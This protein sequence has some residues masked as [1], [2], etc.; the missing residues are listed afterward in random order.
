VTEKASALSIEGERL[1]KE[2]RFEEAVA[3]LQEAVR[4]DPKR[5]A[6]YKHL[7]YALYRLKRYEESVEASEKAIEL[8]NGFEPHYNSGLAYMEL[9]S[10]DKARLAFAF[11]IDYI[12]TGH[13][14]ERYTLAYYYRGRLTKQLG[15]AGQWIKRLEENL[16]ADPEWPRMRF[17]LGILYL[18]VEKRENAIAQYK[19]LKVSDPKLA[20]EL[21]KLIEKRGK[22][23]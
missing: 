9:N 13:W 11:A 5:G 6:A 8:L 23:N 4:I 20:E 22:L 16:K 10:L 3:A 12:D 17:Q 19:I 2:G 1:S 14:E 15:E 21:L 7:G 18:L